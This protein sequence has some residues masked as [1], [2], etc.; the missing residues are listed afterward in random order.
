MFN[1]P[2]KPGSKLA[3]NKK[4]YD[5]YMQIQVKDFKN[6]INLF[7]AKAIPDPDFKYFS[8]S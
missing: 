3:Q 7:L 1:F 6:Y 4:P 5:Y 8:N 2:P